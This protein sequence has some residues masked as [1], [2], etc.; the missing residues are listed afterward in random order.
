LNST[1]RNG[2]HLTAS[3][4]LGTKTR[5][6]KFSTAE[7]IRA[8]KLELKSVKDLLDLIHSHDW[9]DDVD[10]VEGGNVHIYDDHKEQAR[11]MDQ[12]QFANSLGLDLSGIHWLDKQAAVQVR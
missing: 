6:E 3:A 4:I 11:Q 7:A 2:G 12:L 8:I 1:G 10:L 5:A 9:K